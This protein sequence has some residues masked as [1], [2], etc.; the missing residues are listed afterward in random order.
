MFRQKAV[1]QSPLPLKQVD[2]WGVVVCCWLHMSR[3]AVLHFAQQSPVLLAITKVDEQMDRPQSTTAPPRAM[4]RLTPQLGA[5]RVR[6]VSL[7][8]VDVAR[9]PPSTSPA[10]QPL[11]KSADKALF[12]SAPGGLTGGAAAG[13]P[14]LSPKTKTQTWLADNA[15]TTNACGWA[16][17]NG[18]IARARSDATATSDAHAAPL[19]RESVC[20][21]SGSLKGWLGWTPLGRSDSSRLAAG[22]D[23]KRKVRFRD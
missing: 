7:G 10:A 5:Q 23:K 12:P 6:S 20:S 14:T 18:G 9:P 4:D 16:T 11:D 2:A 22:W 8:A 17:R 1:T 13:L 15:S 21:S 3:V 19:R